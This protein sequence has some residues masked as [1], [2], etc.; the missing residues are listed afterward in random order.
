MCIC[1]YLCEGVQ[2]STEVRLMKGDNL[3]TW[4][5]GSCELL[6]AELEPSVKAVN[7]LHHWAVP[8]AL[9]GFLT[10]PASSEICLLHWFYCSELKDTS[11]L[12]TYI[13]LQTHLTPCT[14]FPSLTC[15][16][17]ALPLCWEGATTPSFP[18]FHFF[19]VFFFSGNL[20]FLSL[21]IFLLHCPNCFLKSL[22][23]QVFSIYTGLHVG[24][25]SAVCSVLVFRGRVSHVAQAGLR[26][27]Y[28]IVEDELKFLFP[29]PLS[30]WCWD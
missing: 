30:L 25:Q 7:S 27:T 29:Q 1:V 4:V 15:V 28:C 17:F 9:Y 14:S 18:R 21:A 11:F 24:K 6:E 5:T 23:K 20:L 8:P 16:T 12:P 10:A 19:T 13:S 22:R 3:G 26:L 2:S